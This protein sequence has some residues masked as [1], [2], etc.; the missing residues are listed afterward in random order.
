MH[1]PKSD[2]ECFFS[3]PSNHILFQVFLKLIQYFLR[4]TFSDHWCRSI[5][6]PTNPFLNELRDLCRPLLQLPALPWVCGGTPQV[7][8]HHYFSDKQTE[9]AESRKRWIAGVGGVDHNTHPKGQRVDG[10]VRRT[11]CKHQ[12]INMSILRPVVPR[13]LHNTNLQKRM[14]T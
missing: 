7:H 8:R 6:A 13:T 3:Q 10:K 5:I 14:E 11:S 4:I 9:E 1:Q 12:N 2:Q